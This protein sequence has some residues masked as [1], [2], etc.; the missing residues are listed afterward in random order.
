MKISKFVINNWIWLIAI[1]FTVIVRIIYITKLTGP[2]TVWDEAVYWTHAANLAGVDW[3]GISRTWYSYGYSLLLIPLFWLTH[4]MVVLYRLAILEN[5]LISVGML[6]LFAKLIEVFVP[7]IPRVTKIILATLGVN[8]AAYIYQTQIAW[9]ETLVYFWF[10]VVLLA[11]YRFLQKNTLITSIWFGTSIAL[12]YIIHNRNVIVIIALGILLLIMLISRDI[13]LSH[14]VVIVAAVVVFW[15]ANKYFKGYLVGLEWP[16][17]AI[18]SFSGNDVAASSYKLGLFKSLQG[19]KTLCLSFMG[20]L[21]YILASTFLIGGWGIFY[22]I[23]R[24]SLIEMRKDKN[25]WYLFVF[26]LLC[27]LGYVGI[28]TIINHKISSARIDFVFYGRYQE[29]F[30]GI[31][32]ILGLLEIFNTASSRKLITISTIIGGVFIVSAL[33]LAYM[34]KD[35]ETFYVNVSNIS[36]VKILEYFGA[37]RTTAAVL[38]IYLI[39]MLG[40]L[41]K[42]SEKLKGNMLIN[43]FPVAVLIV[44]ALITYANAMKFVVERQEQWSDKAQIIETINEN[45]DIPVYY[46][47][48]HDDY[49]HWKARIRCMA[50]DNEVYFVMPEVVKDKQYYL[51]SFAETDEIPIGAVSICEST[52]GDVRM[53]AIYD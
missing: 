13:R 36:G 46:L 18:A 53:Y 25:K 20:K 6:F 12:Y 23:K 35:A 31:L 38:V 39:I 4:D 16:D 15:I 50:C 14:V 45:Q 10:L 3:T 22:I 17:G 32:M 11:G 44:C 24:L 34:I 43:Y 21:W 47:G 52:S 49:V 30:T 26:L 37:R 51:L 48:N 33:A 41:M 29:S 7:N 5:I 2:T 42:Q 9:T 40:L 27:I 8:C 1:L 28:N 19:I